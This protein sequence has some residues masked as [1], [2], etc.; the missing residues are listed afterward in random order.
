M[1]DIGALV[2]FLLEE[3]FVFLVCTII[4]GLMMALLV[5]A[6]S[7]DKAGRS[8]AFAPASKKSIRI[9]NETFSLTIADANVENQMAE[10][11]QPTRITPTS[12]FWRWVAGPGAIGLIAPTNDTLSKSDLRLKKKLGSLKGSW[13]LDVRKGYFYQNM[14]RPTP[15]LVSKHCHAEWQRQSALGG[16]EFCSQESSDAIEKAYSNYFSPELGGDPHPPSRIIVTESGREMQ[17]DIRNLDEA[18][19]RNTKKRTPI[20]RT[21]G[22][23]PAC[24]EHKECSC[25]CLKSKQLYELTCHVEYPDGDATVHDGSWMIGIFDSKTNQRLVWQT[26]R[27]KRYNR[28]LH[29]DTELMDRIWECQ[30]IS[31]EGRISGGNMLQ[32]F[33]IPSR[34]SRLCYCTKA[35]RS[36]VFKTSKIYEQG[37]VTSTRQTVT[38]YFCA[39]LKPHEHDTIALQVRL[40]ASGRAVRFHDLTLCKYSTVKQHSL[41]EHFEKF[42]EDRPERIIGKRDCYKTANGDVV[43]AAPE[44]KVKFRKKLASAI[45]REHQWFGVIYVAPNSIFTRARRTGLLMAWFSLQLNLNALWYA[46]K[47]NAGPDAEEWDLPTKAAVGIVSTV[48]LLAFA[49]REHDLCKDCS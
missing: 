43:Y 37:T 18:P 4:Y 25:I 47:A 28:N 9:S 2:A 19:V 13:A 45:L 42:P 11:N 33:K 8:T 44:Q 21:G 48:R 20:R 49:L 17:V 41:K 39:E 26:E 6:R 7:A 3:P 40:A 30:Q 22:E 10:R 24:H 34:C 14:S 32:D 35:E 23:C 31:D 12:F 5:M 27:I 38:L 46:T 1:G 36:R 29:F 16:W 15:K